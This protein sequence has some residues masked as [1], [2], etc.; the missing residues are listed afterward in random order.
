[1]IGSIVA[2]IMDLMGISQTIQIIAFLIV[3]IICLIIFLLVIKPKLNKKTEEK[4]KTNADRIIG[5]EAIV[6]KTINPIENTGQ[7]RVRGQIWS[8]SS[9]DDLVIE[10]D[11]LVI[12]QEIRGVKAFVVA[13]PTD[14]TSPIT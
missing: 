7:I 3:S 10:M 11:S 9:Y 12:V 4:E 1:M 5:Q 14:N 13:K 8:A 2:L 6:L